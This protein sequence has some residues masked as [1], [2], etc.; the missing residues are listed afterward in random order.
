[1]RLI[2][3]VA[4]VLLWH[5][6]CSYKFDYFIKFENVPPPLVVLSAF[7]KHMHETKFYIHIGVSI[8]R[9]LIGFALATAHRHLSRRHHGPLARSRATW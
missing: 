6:A 7:I 4:G 8:E 3:L 1:M 5:L 2:S 9:I